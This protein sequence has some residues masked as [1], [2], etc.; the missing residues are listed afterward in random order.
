MDFVMPRES[1]ETEDAFAPGKNRG[2]AFVLV[3]W[4]PTLTKT[5]CEN[6]FWKQLHLLSAMQAAVSGEWAANEG[7]EREETQEEDQ[8][9]PL[10]PM[11]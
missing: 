10:L 4:A 9:P 1:K 7:E 6:Q 8:S 2:L 3:D 5:I 11:I